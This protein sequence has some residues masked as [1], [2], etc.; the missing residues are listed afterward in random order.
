MKHDGRSAPQ[1][2]EK[3]ILPSESKVGLKILAVRFLECGSRL[4]LCVVDRVDNVGG[5]DFALV[6]VATVETLEGLLA[7]GNR[8][9]LDEDVAVRVDVDGDMNNLAVL[10]VALSLDISLHILRPA[11][12]E[13]VWLPRNILV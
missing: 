6:E 7:T 3:T 12:S 4:E 5:M 9:E 13:L 1:A 10:S 2:N 11:R 8:V